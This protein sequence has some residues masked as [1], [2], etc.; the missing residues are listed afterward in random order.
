MKIAIHQFDSIVGNPKVN[1]LR[2]VTGIK[3][4]VADLHLFGELAL[5]GCY[6]QDIFFNK[7]I[8]KEV[9]FCLQE[10]EN[11]SRETFSSIGVGFS[12]ANKSIGEK[13]LFNTYGVFGRDSFRQN[14]VCLS[15]HEEVNES[16]WFQSGKIESVSVRKIGDEYFGFLTGENDWAGTSDGIA[17]KHFLCEQDLYEKLAGEAKSQ[18]VKLSAFINI[19][20]SPE[21]LGKQK[22]RLGKLSGIAKHYCVPIIFINTVGAQDELIFGGRSFVLN[23]KGELVQE[24]KGFEEDIQIVDTKKIDTMSQVIFSEDKMRELDEMIGCYLK[25]YLRKSGLLDKK[26][27]V[28]LSGGKDS[29][30]VAVALKRHL[31]ADK[32][33]GVMMPYKLGKYTATLSKQI[34]ERLGKTLKIEVREVM[35]DNMVEP[36]RSSLKIAKDSLAHQNLQ[37]RVR[38]NVLWAIANEENGIVINTTNF[39]EAAVGYGTIGGDLLGLPLIASIPATMVVEYLRWLKANGENFLD[40]EMI[41]RPPSAELIP[42]QLDANE[43][44]DY[45]YI[46]PI[47]EALRMSYGNQEKVTKQFL[48]KSVRQYQQY[49]SE[50]ELFEQ[51]LKFLS[52]KLINQTEYKRW[53]YNR[54]PQFTTFSWLRWRWPLANV[55]MNKEP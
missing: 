17:K 52:T 44:G 50:P 30:V 45:D 53:Y 46:D 55:E 15:G 39:S 5:T 34:A 2:M 27:I 22:L 32:V 37:A 12:S 14:K 13:A 25:G 33:L 42:D 24:L 38:A 1:L 26:V 6:A 4:K 51:K 20:A 48:D 11:V 47:L 18:G 16:R 41:S 31:G 9:E 35:I 19:S 43:L 7:Q 3:E 40:E 49:W 29:T 21:Y 10:I 54:T 28:G 23:A 8:Q 36:I